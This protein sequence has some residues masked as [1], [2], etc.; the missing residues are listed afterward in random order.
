MILDQLGLARIPCGINGPPHLRE[1]PAE[2]QRPATTVAKASP[3]FNAPSKLQPRKRR[4]QERWEATIV[5]KA[6]SCG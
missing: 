5:A 4:Q 1:G 3:Q 2:D 6:S